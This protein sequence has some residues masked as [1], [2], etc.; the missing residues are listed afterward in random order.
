MYQKKTN[1][2]KNLL[3]GLIATVILGFVGNAQIANVGFLNTGNKTIRISERGIT[4][5]YTNNSLKYSLYVNQIGTSNNL[6]DFTSTFVITNPVTK[7][8]ISIE[9]IRRKG[10]TFTFDANN[11][12][13]NSAEN[14]DF[15]FEDDNLQN[16]THANPV[17][18]RAIVTIVV[19]GIV[20]LFQDTSLE[21]CKKSMPTNCGTGKTPYMEFSE[22]WFSTTC[23]VGCR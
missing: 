23:N 12:L 15:T 16:V 19:A 7:E 10:N 21:Q 1:I 4:S 9:N 5:V 3:F 11:N 18:V 20:D 2:M 8:Y 13:G 6:P 22:G 17:L 14:L